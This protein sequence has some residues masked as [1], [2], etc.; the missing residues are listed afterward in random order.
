MAKL[1]EEN[2]SPCRSR[3]CWILLVWGNGARNG[4]EKPSWTLSSERASVN[5]Q[6]SSQSKAIILSEHASSNALKPMASET[7]SSVT[8]VLDFLKHLKKHANR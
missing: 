3:D 5:R 8:G 6:S 4:Y 7:K 2:L 1:G